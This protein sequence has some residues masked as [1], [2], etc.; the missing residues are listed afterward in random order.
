MI[1]G[2][3]DGR[4]GRQMAASRTVTDGDE[5]Y[6]ETLKRFSGIHA[7]LVELVRVSADDLSSKESRRV[8]FGEIYGD[9]LSR[10]MDAVE[11]GSE[12]P[13]VLPKA[14]GEHSSE[15]SVWIRSEITERFAAFVGALPYG[16]ESEVLSAALRW[17]FGKKP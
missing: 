10:Y 12:Q 14:K 6:D 9:I 4:K 5:T 2:T 16:N 1:S 15:V 7:D 3:I 8:K 13:A 11:A 17:Y